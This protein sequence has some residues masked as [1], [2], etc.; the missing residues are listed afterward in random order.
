[1][2]KSERTQSFKKR[3]IDNIRKGLIER[4]AQDHWVD[5]LLE[6]NADFLDRMFSGGCS[7]R[8]CVATI[9]NKL[10]E[11]TSES[12]TAFDAGV[13]AFRAG[14]T[15][16]DI[17]AAGTKKF[18]LFWLSGFKS[19]EREALNPSLPVEKYLQISR[20]ADAAYLA[21]RTS[22]VEPACPYNEDTEAFDIWSTR[23]LDLPLIHGDVADDFKVLGIPTEVKLIQTDEDGS[24]L[25]SVAK[26]ANICRND[27]EK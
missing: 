23:M 9:F 13:A 6:D 14:F 2:N 1:M 8:R 12:E 25:Y 10:T 16:D 22:G 3:Y 4:L 7:C 11:W 17:H 20:D 27:F 18:Q 5:E 26:I 21:S 15:L 19:A 24:V